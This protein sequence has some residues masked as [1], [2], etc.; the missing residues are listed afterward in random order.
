MIWTGGAVGKGELKGT[1]FG[2]ERMRDW[3]EVK[4]NSVYPTKEARDLLDS[5]EFEGEK[6]SPSRM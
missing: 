3:V 6:P 1:K 4:E 5:I 2:T